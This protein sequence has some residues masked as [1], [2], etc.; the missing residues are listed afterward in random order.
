VSIGSPEELL[1]MR[2]VGH[3][4][5]LTLQAMRDAVRPGVTTKEL[6]EV[7]ERQLR[8]V[9]ARSA[10]SLVYGFPGWT[11]ISVN[12]EAVHGIP[13]DRV[14][15]PG[16]LVTLDVTAELEGFMADA[17]VTVP[18]AHVDE[19]SARLCSCA[20]EALERGMDAAQPGSPVSAIGRAVEAEVERQGFRVLRELTGHGIGR[21]IHEPPTVHN[22]EA[23]GQTGVLD[24]GTV[25]TIEPIISTTTR[26]ARMLADGWTVATS[27]GSRSAHAEHTIV[28]CQD[29]PLVLTA[30]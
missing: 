27:D 26:S 14:L 22:H 28:V 21:T 18:V 30:A 5:A 24:E 16:D 25:I 17:A 11:C 4:V 10:P 6:D 29:G 9:G 20:A 3:A 15:L 1:A 8:A 7:A 13:G 23:P 19:Q 2:A 12:D